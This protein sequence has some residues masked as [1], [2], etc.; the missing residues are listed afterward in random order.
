MNGSLSRAKLTGS[1]AAVGDQFG[2]SVGISGNI[3][4]IGAPGGAADAGTAYV[5]ARSGTA[6]SERPRLTGSGGPRVGFG[7]AVAISGTTVLV[8]EP[9]SGGGPGKVAA[10]GGLCVRPLWYHLD[11]PGQVDPGGWRRLRPIRPGCRGERVND[12]HR[13]RAPQQRSLARLRSGL[14]SGTTWTEV[15]V[16]SPVAPA[17]YDGFGGSVALDITSAAL[18]GSPG[19]DTAA[20]RDAGSAWVY[21]VGA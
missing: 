16:L 18:V 17:N 8:G 15:A 12:R 21:T 7:A 14:R 19:D 10:G 1:D 4:V 6:W 13:S 9:V 20:G 2:A 11:P 3:A 5:F